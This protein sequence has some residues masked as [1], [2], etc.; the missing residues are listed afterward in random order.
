[1]QTGA[2]LGRPFYFLPCDPLAVHFANILDKSSFSQRDSGNYIVDNSLPAYV[3]CAFGQSEG[4][5]A[6]GNGGD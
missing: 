4:A 1:M 6:A 5:N 2:A 3:S